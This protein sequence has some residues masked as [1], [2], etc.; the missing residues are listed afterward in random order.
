MRVLQ[1]ASENFDPILWLELVIHDIHTYLVSMVSDSD[2]IGVTINSENFARGSAGISLRP[3]ANFCV[4]DLWMLLSGVTQSNENFEVD[5]NFCIEAT[6]VEVP[7]GTGKRKSFGINVL[8]QRSLIFIVR[9]CDNLCL[10]QSLVVGEAFLNLKE[11]ATDAAK[12]VWT[13]IRDGRRS[14]KKDRA[15]MLTAAANLIIPANAVVVYDSNSFGYGEP[16]FFDGRATIRDVQPSKII[17][18]SY[19]ARGHHYDTILNLTGAAKKERNHYVR[20][21]RV[22]GVRIIMR[23]LQPASENFDPIVWLEFVIR[24]IQA[25]LVS[26]ASDSD[27]IGV[28]INS[29]NFARGSAGISLRPVANFFVDDLWMI[30]S[31]VIQSNENFEV[32]DNFCIEATYVEVPLGTGKRKSFGINVL[33]QRSLISIVR[34]RDNLCLPRE[35]FARGSAGIS[36]RPVA[37]FCV[38]DLWML[39]SGV[40]QSNENFEVD[41][42]FCIEA[43]YVEVPLGTGKRKSFGINVLGQ[44]SLI[45]IVRNCDNL[46]LPQ[47]LPTLSYLQMVVDFAKL[48][49]FKTIMRLKI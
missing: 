13:A 5:D 40:T 23:V 46:C 17:N 47:S 38:D 28:T 32:D 27:L 33:G 10:P 19:D 26:I 20:R 7:L 21:F 3:V 30:V 42:N 29:E 44:R 41:D 2:L 35:N 48:K 31:G 37:N 24:D 14:L 45:F 18:I 22:N 16:P 11:D 8:G 34:N 39:L 36:L 12:K 1:P 9:N 4:D 25:Y 49:N 15:F 6:Y 43:T